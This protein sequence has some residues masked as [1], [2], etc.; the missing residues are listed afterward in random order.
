MTRP[1]PIIFA[2][3][4]SKVKKFFAKTSYMHVR[5]VE[6]FSHTSW[7]A[8]WPRYFKGKVSMNNS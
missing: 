7:D 2:L 6:N 3:V 8:V 5:G 4:E 1:V